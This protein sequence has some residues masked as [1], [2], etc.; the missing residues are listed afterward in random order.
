MDMTP[1]RVSLC[2]HIVDAHKTQ[3]QSSEKAALPNNWLKNSLRILPDAAVML[4]GK[5]Q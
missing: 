3:K 2:Q 1:L 4:R 5:E